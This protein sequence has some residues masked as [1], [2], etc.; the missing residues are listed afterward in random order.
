MWREAQDIFIMEHGVFIQWE[1]LVG[2]GIP[3]VIVCGGV[4]GYLVKFTK[5]ITVLQQKVSSLT[6]HDAGATDTH[7]D[8]FSRLDR[9]DRNMYLIMGKMKLTPV[10]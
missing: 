2:V 3:A 7:K 4:I 6:N 1:L 10:D 8:I 5:C 9:I